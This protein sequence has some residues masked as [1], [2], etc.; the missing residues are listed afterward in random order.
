MLEHLRKHPNQFGS[1]NALSISAFFG[2]ATTWTS[3]AITWKQPLLARMAQQVLSSVYVR[4]LR[5]HGLDH[6]D[7]IKTMH[8][9]GLSFEIFG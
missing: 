3:L 6:I 4:R 5:L 9:L 1:D 8:Q 2:L 7:T